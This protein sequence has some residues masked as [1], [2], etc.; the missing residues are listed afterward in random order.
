MARTVKL[1]N[2][3]EDPV[4]AP[5]FTLPVSIIA[6]VIPQL[7]VNIS[8]QSIPTLNINI[9]SISQ[10]ITVTTT[11]SNMPS[12]FPLPSDQLSQLQQVTIAD[13]AAGL[14]F[15]V[16]VS[17]VD[18]VLNI[19][20]WPSTYPLPSDQIS[21]LQQITIQN[22]AAGL[23]IPIDIK[24]ITAE[25]NINN[26]PS[27]YPLPDS[28]VS[29]LQ[30]ITIQNVAAGLYIPINIAKADAVVNSNAIISGVVAGVYVPITIHSVDTGVVF[31]INITNVQSGVVFNVNITGT[32]TINVQTS[33]GANIV[34]DQLTQSAYTERQSTLANNGNTPTMVAYNLSAKRGKLFPRGCRGFIK[35]VEIYC[36]NADSVSHTFTLKLSPMPSMGP[37]ATFTLSVA[38]DSSAAWRTIN[39][40]RFWNYDSLFIWV[41]C[42]S[43]SYGQLAYDTG[44]PYDYYL[45]TDEVTWTPAS[46]RYWF[47][48]NMTGE[49]VGDLPVSGTLNVIEVPS[50]ASKYDSGIVS[51]PNNTLTAL[52]TVYG[53]GTLLEARVDFGTNTA[54]STIVRYAIYLEVDGVLVHTA[55]N[56]LITQSE[57]STGGMCSIGEF[58]QTGAP[59]SILTVRLPLKFKRSIRLYALQ[60]T[61]IAVNAGGTLLVSLIS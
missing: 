14:V 29:T 61:G 59:A 38:A 1:L 22:V 31:D 18:A 17:H 47:R 27:S 54:P 2:N 58:V 13:I 9:A 53:A 25:L 8:A 36:D 30:Q 6:Q 3:G 15:N 56:K 24:Q 16:N 55:D 51:V 43:D 41:S 48:V 10:G 35:T 57:T 45:S 44:A 7:D 34:I 60:S 12:T 4:G 50:V 52:C 28:Q 20:N 42:D 49:T 11:V 23:F 33:G 39:V 37:F 32:P 46:Y 21:T 5:D 19:N 26:F 40:K